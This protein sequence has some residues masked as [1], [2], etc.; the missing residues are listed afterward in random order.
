M[1]RPETPDERVEEALRHVLADEAAHVRIAGDGLE[2]IRARTAPTV[3]WWRRAL[4]PA[5][6]A[7]AVT[8]VAVGVGAVVADRDAGPPVAGPVSPTSTETP[9]TTAAP[10]RAVPVYYV[11]QVEGLG[12][13]L[14]REFHRLPETDDVALA[15]LRQMVAGP[16]DPDHQTLWTDQVLDVSRRGD[17]AVV[18]RLDTDAA[19]RV[20]PDAPLAQQLV[21]TATAALGETVPVEVVNRDGANL[22]TAERAPELDVLALVQLDDPAEGAEVGKQITVRGRAAAY[23]ATLLWRLLRDGAVVVDGFANTAEGQRFAP[24]EF[25][26]TA[27]GPGT[28]VVEVAESS[29]ASPGEGRPPFAETRTVV[30]R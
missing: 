8:A 24:Y 14:A 15:A 3:P 22:F 12:Q 30:V 18:V 13:R 11:V 1:T 2:R 10:T 17:G 28:Y 21:Y 6:A 23:E 27:P 9:T 16:A 19:L 29:G 7:A 26:I 25:T 20:A 4:V 5:L